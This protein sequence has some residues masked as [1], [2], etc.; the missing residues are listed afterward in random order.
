M[1]R[2]QHRRVRDSTAGGLLVMSTA[3][4]LHEPMAPPMAAAI[5]ST[6]SVSWRNACRRPM[7][8]LA[9]WPS[10]TAGRGWSA[11]RTLFRD[12]DPEAWRR[13][14][15]NP[16]YVIE[17]AAPRRFQELARD[18]S[19]VARVQAHGRCRGRRPAAAGMPVAGQTRAAGRVLLLGVRHPLL[20]AA[21]RRRSRRAGRRHAEGGLRPRPCRWS[22][23]A[24]STAR[25]TSTSGS[26]SRAGST[27]TGPTPTS[28]ACRRCASPAPSSGR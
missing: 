18:A 12:I 7:Q 25:A 22:A 13:S 24:C 23:S 14:G 26:T 27:S 3:I 1:P 15:C 2:L 9:A 6:R 10:T 20:A 11:G 5:S 8:P 16:R 17:A 19:Y 4:P 21:L 28:S